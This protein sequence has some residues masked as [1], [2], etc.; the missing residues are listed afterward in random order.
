MSDVISSNVRPCRRF[1]DSGHTVTRPEVHA[2][3]VRRVVTPR[4]ALKMHC[5]YI[6]RK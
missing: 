5:T 1:A 2:C 3:E 6:G 4:G